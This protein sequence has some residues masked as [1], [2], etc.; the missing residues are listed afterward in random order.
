MKEKEKGP[1]IEIMAMKE[2][3]SIIEKTMPEK[4]PI[5]EIM[6]MTEEG[7]I[8]PVDQPRQKEY[9]P[10]TNRDVQEIGE[11]GNDGIWP[12]NADEMKFG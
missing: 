8:I 11:N 2:K 12:L 10:S 4:G 9:T 1:F 7:S 5:I 6:T 3:G